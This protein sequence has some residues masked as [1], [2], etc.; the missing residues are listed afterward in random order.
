MFI[1]DDDDKT[2]LMIKDNIEEVAAGIR[3]Q[4]KTSEVLKLSDVYRVYGN[5]KKAVNGISITM[6]N[7]QIFCLLGHNGAGKTSLISMLTGMLEFSSGS[8]IVYG[9]DI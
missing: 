7:S 8:A 5:G 4:E 3:V 1:V 6:Y 2:N 9:K